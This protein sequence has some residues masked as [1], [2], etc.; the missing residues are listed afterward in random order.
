MNHGID[1]NF[2]IFLIISA[3]SIVSPAHHEAVLGVKYVL[4]WQFRQRANSIACREEN[5]CSLGVF[6]TG[7][8]D[9]F[10]NKRRHVL[11]IYLSILFRLTGAFFQIAVKIYLNQIFLI[12]FFSWQAI[13]LQIIFLY[14]KMKI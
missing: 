11:V 4:E 2:L 9:A 6:T 5:F 14:S 3:Y 7:N 10:F 13:G 8:D 12:N 1:S